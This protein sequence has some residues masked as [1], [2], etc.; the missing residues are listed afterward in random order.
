LLRFLADTNLVDSAVRLATNPITIAWLLPY[1]SP[2]GRS[3][4]AGRLESSVESALSRIAPASPRH[5]AL[6]EAIR[7]AYQRTAKAKDRE[8]K[9]RHRLS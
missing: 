1:A 5:L 8:D 4:V 9:T 3:A 2:T 6:V 7:L